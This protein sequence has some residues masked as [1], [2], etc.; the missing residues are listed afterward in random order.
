M[1]LDCH[2]IRKLAGNLRVI[3]EIQ[4]NY[5]ESKEIRIKN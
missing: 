3:T 4:E 5:Q 1:L 2:T